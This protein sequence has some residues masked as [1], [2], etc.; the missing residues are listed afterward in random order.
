MGKGIFIY[1]FFW[2]FE[3][4]ISKTNKFH[5]IFMKINKDIISLDFF[6]EN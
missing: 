5:E 1:I 4:R 2:K 3:I 6:F